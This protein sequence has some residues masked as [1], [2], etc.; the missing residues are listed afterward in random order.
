MKSQIKKRNPKIVML[1]GI[2][3]ITFFALSV[4]GGLNIAQAFNWGDKKGRDRCL[5]SKKDQQAPIRFSRAIS[6]GDTI[7]PGQKVRLKQ[8]LNCA[9]TDFEAAI[10]ING[11][12]V[13]DLNGHTITGH[14]QM[15]G[16]VVQGEKAKI[17]NGRV[18]GFLRGVYLKGRGI[19]GHHRI[20][21]IRADEN[22]VGFFVESNNNVLVQ[23][24]AKSSEYGAFMI[25]GDKNKIRSNKAKANVSDGFTIGG[26]ENR[27]VH[28][29]SKNNENTGIEINGEKNF[30]A[31]NKSMNNTGV[32]IEVDGDENKVR[33]N[34]LKNNG[35]AGIDLL[36]GAATNVMVRNIAKGNNANG[37]DDVYDV[38]DLNE[39]C[40]DNKWGNNRFRTSNQDCIN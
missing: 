39:D 35:S 33:R 17:K 14:D 5:I 22:F 28:N 1:V 4:E 27:I 23:N 26:A 38:Q 15:E 12:A 29:I 25:Y 8:D 6:C 21:K 32:G 37:A 34:I 11:P 20:S 30:I 40:A 3:M 31:K 16:I 24:L 7:E 19:E 9:E 2:I 13:L 18:T 10:T 36:P